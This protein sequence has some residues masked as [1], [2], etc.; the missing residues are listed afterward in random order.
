LKFNDRNFK[1]TSC[2]LDANWGRQIFLDSHEC[3]WEQL[4]A[5][6]I[7]P[8]PDENSCK[9]KFMSINNDLGRVYYHWKASGNGDQQ[10]SCT[11]EEG[12]GKIDVDLLPTQGGDR[13]N[14][15]GIYNICVMYLWFLL[16]KTETF[17]FA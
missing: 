15:L 10:L 13:I 17:L 7:K 14:F 5:L 4:D 6:E 9:Q 16:V 12:T 2:R 8:I 3:N 11:L 1:V